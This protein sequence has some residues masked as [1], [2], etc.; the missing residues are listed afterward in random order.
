VPGVRYARAPT[1]YGDWWLAW[2]PAGVCAG[3][4][5]G[6]T[7]ERFLAWLRR[8][9]GGGVERGAAGDV[10]RQIDWRLVPPG[11]RRDVLAACARIPAGTTMSYAELAAA[12][13]HPGA[14][15][16]VGSAMATNPLPPVVPCHRVVRSDGRI[17]EYSA[18]GPARKAAML[19]A[20]GVEVRDGAVRR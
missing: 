3:A 18:G 15:R 4:D 20:E 16:A 8:R 7:E 11:F 12:A 9:L 17:G 2:T 19:L 10:P 5:P 13:G 14:A 6:W 1:P